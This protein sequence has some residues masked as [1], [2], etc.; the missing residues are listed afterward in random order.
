MVSIIVPKISISILHNFP[1]VPGVPDVVV[2]LGQILRQRTKYVARA[3]NTHKISMARRVGEENRI[4]SCF[5]ASRRIA[6]RRIGSHE[7]A[8]NSQVIVRSLTSDRAKYGSPCVKRDDTRRECEKAAVW[9]SGPVLQ[10]PGPNARGHLGWLMPL[11]GVLKRESRQQWRCPRLAIWIPSTARTRRISLCSLSFIV[12][13]SYRSLSVRIRTPSEKTP[14]VNWTTDLPFCFQN[15][16]EPPFVP[17]LNLK[18]WTL[19]NRQICMRV[20]WF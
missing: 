2:S 16:T 15:R 14:F 12:H 11:S 8:P 9:Y 4:A 17:C 13:L 3:F 10:G 6:S 1:G 18:N 7:K 20:F 19:A 5:A